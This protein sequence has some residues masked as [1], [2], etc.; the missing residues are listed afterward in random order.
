MK[1]KASKPVAQKGVRKSRAQRL[2]EMASAA[3]TSR[4][5]K[6]KPWEPTE[7][8]YSWYVLWTAELWSVRRIALHAKRAHSAVR[9]T[10]LRVQEWE[11]DALLESRI[12]IA[13]R[14]TR[15]LEGA[16][17]KAGE[18]YQLS[19]ENAV[20]IKT[21][22]IEL[23]GFDKDGNMVSVPAI[24]TTRTEAGQAGDAS[25]LNVQLK[26]LQDIRA[27]WG[28]DA[29]KESKISATLGD[30]SGLVPITQA[31]RQ[32]TIKAQLR[33]TLERLEGYAVD[34]GAAD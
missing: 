26:S 11:F 4:Q 30:Q 5:R 27:I 21:E 32:E 16:F 17:V 10:L 14:H 1:K 19:L 2:T 22:E 15:S 9:K 3:P 33:A 24:K 29:P 20:T 13:K 7:I 18:S 25:F 12:A 6:A 8:Q 23:S 28:V 34:A 31:N